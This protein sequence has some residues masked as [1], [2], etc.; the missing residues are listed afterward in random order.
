MA[1]TAAER[2]VR[3]CNEA[4]GSPM[5]DQGTFYCKLPPKAINPGQINPTSMRTY[6]VTYRL[7]TITPNTKLN[8]IDVFAMDP[9]DA[10]LKAKAQAVYPF[11]LGNTQPIFQLQQVIEFNACTINRGPINL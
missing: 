1:E 5:Y 2:Q 4:G 6:K 3:V 10:A 8:T 11:I 7:G 9:K